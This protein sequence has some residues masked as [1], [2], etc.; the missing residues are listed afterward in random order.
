VATSTH[1]SNAELS[2]RC[3]CGLNNV[4]PKLLG[5]LEQLRVLIRHPLIINSASRCPIYNQYVGGVPG[6]AHTTGDAVDIA[7]ISDEDRFNLIRLLLELGFCRLGV[8]PDFVH[9][10]TS[11]TLPQAVIW[12]YPPR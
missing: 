2:C 8:G 7:C 9:C 1:F 3:H 4:T 6:G 5:K 12:V 10:D 11:N